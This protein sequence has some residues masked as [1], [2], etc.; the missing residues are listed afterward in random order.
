MLII[1]KISLIPVME[2]IIEPTI[3]FD[4][5][6]LYLAAPSSLTGGA[7]FT[8]IFLNNKPLY[9][10]TP[11]CLTKQGFIKSGK[12]IYT[13]LMFDNN[14]TLLIQWLENLETKCQEL[15]YE[16][17]TQW[18]ETTLE[19]SDIET[20][21]TS[22]IKIF[23]SGKFYLLRVNVKPNIK[24]Y[25]E[26][27]EVITLENINQDMHII[28]ILE[29]Q[30]IKFTSRNFQIEIEVKQSMVVSQD[31]FLD[32]CF[33]KKPILRN[34]PNQ[35]D[36]RSVITSNSNPFSNILN[37]E[38]KMI[39][40]PNVLKDETVSTSLNHLD[41]KTDDLTEIQF[42]DLDNDMETISLKKPN[43]VYYKIYKAARE[44]AKQAKKEAILAYLEAKNIKKT[45]MLDDIEDSD[46][47]LENT[48]EISENEEFS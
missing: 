16:K 22:P 11:K 38:N 25:N 42:E 33:I 21:F 9:I 31:P 20:T 5:S 17:G 6:K 27:D 3:D 24:I 10:Q 7:Y 46:S 47:D 19:K 37:N 32:E 36:N 18:F 40:E 1:L 35:K 2:N 14:D 8:R 39:L 15:I 44:K 30:G 13:D 4:F 26:L 29:I 41:I 43:E 48:S 34:Y 28:S 45:Y 12:K 23:K